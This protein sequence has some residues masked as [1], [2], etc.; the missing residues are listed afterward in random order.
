MKGYYL[1]YSEDDIRTADR[2]LTGIENKVL[3]QVKTFNEEGLPFEL[4]VMIHTIGGLWSK[5]V[6]RLPFGSD[7]VHYPD[8]RDLADADWIYIRKHYIIY[9]LRRFLKQLRRQNPHCKVVFEIPTYPYDK[10]FMQIGVKVW[11]ILWRERYTRRH[12][13]GLIDRYA[14]IGGEG[15]DSLWGVPTVPLMN[16]IRLKDTTLRS[17]ADGNGQI[18]ILCVSYFTRYHAIDL[19][20]AGLEAYYAQ[21][22][23]RDIQLY[24]VGEGHAWPEL[25]GLVAQSEVLQKHVH[26][27][28]PRTVAELDPYYDLCDLG[29]HGYG[30][31]RQM[32]TGGQK[33][34]C[35]SAIKTRE[36]LAKGLPFMGNMVD[37]FVGKDIPFFL[38]CPLGETPVDIESV[39]RFYGTLY[40]HDTRE[41]K[42]A[43][44]RQ[45]RAFAEQTVDM[46]QALG[47]VISYFKE[48]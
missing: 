1:Y 37:V 42:L 33:I 23:V 6:S 16:G 34:P 39:V 31:H 5:I 18:K 46:R 27:E 21:G 36:Y 35:A 22:G 2:K 4:V 8:V 20:F 11:P 28:G 10:E 25:T 41:E 24:L 40:P 38:N 9:P 7:G 3:D 13:R 15:L 43:W 32:D 26:L 12:M 45:M 30:L 44:A 47:G 48:G 29:I 19:F 14:P 17:P